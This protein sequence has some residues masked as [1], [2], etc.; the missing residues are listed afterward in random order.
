[1]LTIFQCW[2]C[3][4]IV[5]ASCVTAVAYVMGTAAPPPPS[6]DAL[7]SEMR[8][9][10]RDAVGSKGIGQC[11]EKLAWSIIRPLTHLA[12]A[13]HAEVGR[14]ARLH[15]Y[16]N[17]RLL[18]H[19]RGPARQAW[20]GCR[21][22]LE[23]C[24]NVIRQAAQPKGHVPTATSPPRSMG[25]HRLHHTRTCPAS[26]HAS[27]CCVRAGSISCVTSRWLKDFPPC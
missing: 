17:R 21:D 5:V 9:I 16:L 12:L 6:H 24:C 22:F 11:M 3:R 13:A 1:M 20:E 18:G 2:T 7:T 10:T 4:G 14:L 8:I 23:T 15:R 25:S 27:V 26:R 19:S